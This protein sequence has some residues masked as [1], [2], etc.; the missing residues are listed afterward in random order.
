MLAAINWRVQFTYRRFNR[1]SDGFLQSLGSTKPTQSTG[2]QTLCVGSTGIKKIHGVHLSYIS[3]VPAPPASLPLFHPRSP[4]TPPPDSI[5]T[6]AARLDSRRRR[7]SMPPHPRSP[8][9]TP[10]LACTP[11]ARVAAAAHPPQRILRRSAHAPAP[12]PPTRRPCA[13]ATVCLHAAVR[14]RAAVPAPH[15][16]HAA[17]APDQRSPGVRGFD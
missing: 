3:L 14:V 4:F 1:R 8:T 7:R 13:A 15:P 16:F 5:R 2:V 17:A 11:Q 9:L 6:A 12:A 10:P